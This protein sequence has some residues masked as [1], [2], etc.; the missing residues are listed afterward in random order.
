MKK[1]GLFCLF[2]VVLIS[3][4]AAFPVAE[5]S[6]AESIVVEYNEPKT[7]VRFESPLA[8]WSLVLGLLWMPLMLAF[9]ILLWTGPEEIAIILF[10]AGVASF[11][12]AIVTGFMSLFKEDSGKWKVFVGLGLTLGIILLSI[13]SALL[14]NGSFLY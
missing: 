7:P 1:I 10:I 11:I 3:S 6:T 2:S 8:N 12:G 13:F 14:E 4:F 5:S 9:V